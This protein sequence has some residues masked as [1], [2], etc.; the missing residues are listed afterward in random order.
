MR[1]IKKEGGKEGRK[2]EKKIS[3]LKQLIPSENLCD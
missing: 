3:P 2:E 1:L